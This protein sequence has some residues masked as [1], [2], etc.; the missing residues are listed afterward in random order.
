MHPD[1]PTKVAYLGTATITWSGTSG[2]VFTY[3]SILIQNEPKLSKISD[4]RFGSDFYA[5][6]TKR[7]W[8]KIVFRINS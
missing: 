1:T 3:D 8:A 7:K 2:P 6:N 5:D 4:N